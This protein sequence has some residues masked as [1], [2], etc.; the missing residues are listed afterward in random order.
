MPSNKKTAKKRSTT[1]SVH[2]IFFPLV[3][4][5]FILWVCYRA[6]FSFPVWFDEIIAKALLFGLPVW[7]YVAAT[8]FR[9][10]GESFA[11]YKLRT[12]TL[13]GVL[14]G[15]LFGFT[16]S[17]MRLV[18][19]GGEVFAVDLFAAPAFWI[20]FV[21]ALSTGFWETVLFFSFI[22]GVLLHKHADWSLSKQ[23]LV[24]AGVFTLFH[25]PNTIARFSPQLIIPQILLLF[26][27]AIG[28]G[29]LYVSRKNAYILVLSH[30]IWGM[31]LLTHSW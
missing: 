7:L 14:A 11:L 15:G 3:T 25:I 28:Q 1:V 30:A 19:S 8:R 16:T 5:T 2:V 27:F 24:A 9:G 26:L 12:G 20:E 31:V 4:F 29:L 22:L 21:L 13:I 18:Q 23:V 10:V 17:V 6:F